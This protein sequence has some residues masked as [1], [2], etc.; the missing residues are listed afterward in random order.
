MVSYHEL[1]PRFVALEQRISAIERHLGI[2][3]FSG[4]DTASSGTGATTL[5]DGRAVPAP[6]QEV[7]DFVRA[8]DLI[9][10]IKAYR[11]QTNYGLAEAKAVVE[12][13]RGL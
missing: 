12:Q 7:L 6:S 8:G 9:R 4:G 1:E 5:P 13:L 10:A 3:P 2:S 11:E